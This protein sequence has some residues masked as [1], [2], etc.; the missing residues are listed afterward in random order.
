MFSLIQEM[1][2]T[3]LDTS[4]K[5]SENEVKANEI[6]MSN[7][8]LMASEDSDQENTKNTEREGGDEDAPNVPEIAEEF[9]KLKDIKLSFEYWRFQ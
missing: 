7:L 4:S 8:A 6:E 3:D 1:I 9:S 2:I 5:E